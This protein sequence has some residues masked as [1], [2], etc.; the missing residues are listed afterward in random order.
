VVYRISQLCGNLRLVQE[1]NFFGPL[2]LREVR[3]ILPSIVESALAMERQDLVVK[4][5]SAMF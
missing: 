3:M 1:S 2:T 4:L 5:E